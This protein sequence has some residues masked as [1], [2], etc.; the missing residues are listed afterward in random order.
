MFS[1]QNL[2]KILYRAANEEKYVDPVKIKEILCVANKMTPLDEEGVTVA[3]NE[4][5]EEGIVIG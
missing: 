2:A 1:F 3:N 5:A 4:Q